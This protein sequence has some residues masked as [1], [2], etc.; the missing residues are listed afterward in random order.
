MLQ[1]EEHPP[2]QLDGESWLLVRGGVKIAE[3]TFMSSGGRQ[4]RRV[5]ATEATRQRVV[6]AREGNRM[7]MERTEGVACVQTAAKS[8]TK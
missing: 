2:R 8:G 6:A 7:E 4:S 1:E 5:G 3:P